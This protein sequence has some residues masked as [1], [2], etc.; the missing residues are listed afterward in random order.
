MS[1][2]RAVIHIAREWKKLQPPSPTSAHSAQATSRSSD[3]EMSLP[4]GEV[5]D[6]GFVNESDDDEEAAPEPDAPRTTAMVSYLTRS[7]FHTHGYTGP[8]HHHA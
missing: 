8:G 1:T 4:P 6:G 5:L 3:V 7:R 2:D